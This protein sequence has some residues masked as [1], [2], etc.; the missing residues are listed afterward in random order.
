MIIIVAITG[1]CS[2]AI[3][4]FSLGFSFRIYKFMFILLGYLFGLLG[5]AIGLFVGLSVLVNLKSFGIPYFAPY[6]PNSELNPNASFFQA[7]VWQKENRLN[8]LK[9]K[10]PNEEAYISRKWQFRKG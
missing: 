1:I 4:D 3:P 6:S 10:R 5:I 7:P 9:T 8:F 2:F